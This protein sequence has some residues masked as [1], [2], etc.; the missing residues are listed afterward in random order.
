MTHC[1]KCSRVRS[2]LQ[3]KESV[4]NAHEECDGCVFSSRLKRR[5]PFTHR[6]V[7]PA[8]AVTLACEI[9]VSNGPFSTTLPN[10]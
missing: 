2:E 5:E 8:T 7:R 3:T 1:V 6:G 10:P 4:L 9:H